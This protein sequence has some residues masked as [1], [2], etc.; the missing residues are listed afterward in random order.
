MTINDEI[1]ALPRN[2]RVAFQG[3]LT[4]NLYDKTWCAMG[5]LDY[6]DP[7][8]QR[9]KEILYIELEERGLMQTLGEPLSLQSAFCQE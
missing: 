1:N 3:L 2:Q 4:N 7:D 8:I 6:L 9:A 5:G